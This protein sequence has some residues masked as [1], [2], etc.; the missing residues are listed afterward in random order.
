MTHSPR[1]EKQPERVTQKA[2]EIFNTNRTRCKPRAREKTFTQKMREA[3]TL[4]GIEKQRAK[5]RQ[6]AGNNQHRVK[7]IFPE[8]ETGQTRDKVAKQT[9]IGSGKTYDTAKQN[10]RLVPVY[11]TGTG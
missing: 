10:K 5:D 4:E 2:A 11:Y 7:E 9:G 1:L 3:E 6:E 8:R